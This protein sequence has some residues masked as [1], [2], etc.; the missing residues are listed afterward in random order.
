MIE[1]IAIVN[2]LVKSGIKNSELGL[3]PH[4]SQAQFLKLVH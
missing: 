4:P 2:Q 3:R 1:L